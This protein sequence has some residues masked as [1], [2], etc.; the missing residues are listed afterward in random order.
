[1]RKYSLL[2]AVLLA[3]IVTGCGGQP[4]ASAS[5]TATPV[6][7][8]ETDV[9]SPEPDPTSVPSPTP[10]ADASTEESPAGPSPSAAASCVAAD[11]EFPV[12][13]GLSPVTAADHVRGSEDA[14]MTLIVYSDFQ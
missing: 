14:S 11:A 4:D 5:V 7:A 13:P 2:A 1:M 6:A 3:V 8:A 9:P 10:A 12:A